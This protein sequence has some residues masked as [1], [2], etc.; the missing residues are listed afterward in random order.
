M[1]RFMDAPDV[2]AAWAML[3]RGETAED[4]RVRETQERLQA[5]AYGM[6]H[7]ERDEVVP[8]C[9]QHSVLDDAENAVLARRLP[10]HPAP[11]S[12]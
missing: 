4:P 8:A 7:P 6:A 2:A 12:R 1:H 11:R 10:L 9:V 5:C 3:Q